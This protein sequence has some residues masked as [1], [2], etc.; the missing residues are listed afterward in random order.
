[1]NYVQVSEST[2]CDLLNCKSKI[3]DLTLLVD[4]YAAQL[5]TMGFLVDFRNILMT[6]GCNSADNRTLDDN[7]GN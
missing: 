7:G 1:M 3:T 5:H 4:R 6:N 2:L